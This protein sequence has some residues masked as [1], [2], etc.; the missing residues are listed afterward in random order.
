MKK[1]L[2][3]QLKILKKYETILKKAKS[4]EKNKDYENTLN[5]YIKLNNCPQYQDRFNRH[6]C[7]LYHKMNNYQ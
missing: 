2:K 4:Y 3:N 5:L 7:S 1:N 6:I